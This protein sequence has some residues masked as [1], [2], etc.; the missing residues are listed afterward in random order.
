MSALKKQQQSVIKKRLTQSPVV[1]IM[2]LQRWHETKVLFKTQS[3]ESKIG[4]YCH[5]VDIWNS[6]GQGEA[7]EGFRETLPVRVQGKTSPIYHT[8]SSFPRSQVLKGFA[9]EVI[10]SECLVR[11]WYRETEEESNP[12]Q[13]R[14]LS[15]GCASTRSQA[16]QICSFT[17][18]LSKQQASKAELSQ[19]CIQ[20]QEIILPCCLCGILR[21]FLYFWWL[22]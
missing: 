11:R 9:V 7:R 5:L 3:N 16:G 20:D 12:A 8:T 6:L 4:C 2:P 14:Q 19:K 22:R 1:Q 15:G 18:L 10:D 13:R 21:Q 17:V